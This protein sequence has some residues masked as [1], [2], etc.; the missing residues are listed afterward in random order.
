MHSPIM[1]HHTQAVTAYEQFLADNAII[2]R[3]YYC[4]EKS[5]YLGYSSS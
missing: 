3:L 5:F 4:H 1:L 2:T